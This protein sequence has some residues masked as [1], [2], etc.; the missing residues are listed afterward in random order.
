MYVRDS[1]VGERRLIARDKWTF[2]DDRHVTL[3]GGFDPGKI[4]EVIYKAK[5]PVLER[6]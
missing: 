2:A 6:G 4:Y 5:D 3:E 1:V